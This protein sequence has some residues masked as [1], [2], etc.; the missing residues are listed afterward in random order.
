MYLCC[1][2]FRIFNKFWLSKR[3]GKEKGHQLTPLWLSASNL[4]AGA[5]SLRLAIG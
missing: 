2:L 4:G 1:T 5:T 3:T